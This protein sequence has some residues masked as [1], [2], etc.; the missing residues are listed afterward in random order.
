[1]TPSSSSQEGGWWL[2]LTFAEGGK[3]RDA[4]VA[5]GPDGTLRSRSWL[6][7]HGTLS[8]TDTLFVQPDGQVLGLVPTDAGV[9][10]HAWGRP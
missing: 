1:L 4:L 10:L 8:W 7:E 9:A 3:P 5:L 2:R 6:P